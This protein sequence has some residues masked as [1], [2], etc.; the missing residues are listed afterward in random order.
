M[1]DSKSAFL[2]LVLFFLA[3]LA[4]ASAAIF[5]YWLF[6]VLIVFVLML[7]TAISNPVWAV[8]LLLLFASGLIPPQLTPNLPL[9][10]GTIK[11][12]DL[13]LLL[14]V[15]LTAFRVI[16]TVD[17]SN[18]WGSSLIRPLYFFFLLVVLSLITAVLFNGN[19]LKYIAYEFR[20]CIYWLF[21]I[22]LAFE[23]KAEKSVRLAVNF[24]VSLSVIL[25][26]VVIIQSFT[27][28]QILSNSRVEFLDSAGVVSSG[29]SRSTFGG[30]QNFVVLSILIVLAKLSEGEVKPIWAVPVLLILVAG[31]VVTFGRGVWAAAFLSTVVMAIGLGRKHL[32]RIATF[33]IAISLIFLIVVISAKPELL[34]AVVQRFSSVEREMQGGESWRWRQA[35]NEFALA[36]IGK[37]PIS[38]IGLGGEYQP[39]RNRF[40]SPEQTRMMHNSYL[41]LILK[42]GLLGIVFPIWFCVAIWVEC[43]R[44][45][46]LPY[47]KKYRTIVIAVGAALLMPVLTGVTQPEWMEHKG[48]LFMAS[49]FGIVASL[50][51][52]ENK[53]VT[54]G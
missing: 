14:L 7:A 9:L 6:L 44:L 45:A 21:G 46:K 41:Y 54:V 49:I 31:I 17:R 36:K 2:A 20:V 34:E 35:E 23:L 3:L 42:L 1:Q 4:G 47:M 24:I 12:E 11:A 18:L 30:Y 22:V 48:V 43:R 38:G 32:I 39:I 53:P 15:L 25:A 16:L 13:F 37:S 26:I 28:W 27:G 33:G 50:S 40:M 8:L 10:G 19:Q 52:F 51:R 5:P 29:V